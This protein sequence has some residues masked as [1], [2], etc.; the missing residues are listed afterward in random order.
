MKK[1]TFLF[2][3]SISISANSQNWELF[4][5]DQKMY[6]QEFTQWDTTKVDLYLNDSIKIAGQDKVLYFRKKITLEAIEECYNEFVAYL[7]YTG[8]FFFIDSLVQRE[9]TIFYHWTGSSTPF[10]FLPKATVGQS[11]IVKSTYNQNDFDEITITCSNIEPESF[12]GIID[13]IKT[14][15]LQANGTDDNNPPIDSFVIKLSKHYGL[16]EFVPFI[17]FLFHPGPAYGYR[18]LKLIGIDSLGSKRGYQQPKFEDYFH[19]SEGDILFWHRLHHSDFINYPD[20]HEYYK[21]SITQVISTADSIIYIYDR[22]KQDRDGDIFFYNALSKIYLKIN[23]KNI[24]ETPPNWLGYGNNNL[25]NGP[26]QNPIQ[27]WF[28]DYLS[29]RTDQITGDTATAF[30]F[31]SADLSIDT[32]DCE[33]YESIDSGYSFKVD[34]RYGVWQHCYYSFGS[35]CVLL[36]GSKIDG[37]QNGNLDFPTA[38]NEISD[39]FPIQ[40]HPNPASNSITISNLDYQKELNYKIITS[41]GQLVKSGNL[42]SNEIQINNLVPGFYF[43]LLLNEESL[44]R[45]MFIKQ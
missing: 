12:L 27:L 15:T 14:F 45:G 25:G 29:I 38:T 31:W 39:V 3:L 5:K 20:W 28:S 10:Y 16:I 7:N 37:K 34:T 30:S 11:W 26:I 19:L 44:F 18:L 17:R 9:D 2:A 6:F 24:V 42:S 23:F 33:I 40:I 1:I 41:T 21:D 36:T 22:V 35:D 4:P 32:S 13:S 43:I 8:N